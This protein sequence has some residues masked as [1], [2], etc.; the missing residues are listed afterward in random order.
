M[1]VVLPFDDEVLRTALLEAYTST[2][3][4]FDAMLR[5]LQTVQRM[6]HRAL[7]RLRRGEITEAEY[8]EQRDAA[9][10]LCLQGAPCD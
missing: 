10:T 8:H 5:R 2:L 6:G 3:S 1:I 7:R 9:R 4:D